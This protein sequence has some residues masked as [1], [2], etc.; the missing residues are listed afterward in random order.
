MKGLKKIIAYLLGYLKDVFPIKGAN[1]KDA[2]SSI[3][4]LFSLFTFLAMAIWF[5]YTYNF[6]RGILDKERN[7]G[8]YFIW[9]MIYYAVP[10]LIGA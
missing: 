9:N 10:Y 8:L 7:R 3:L 6:E 4:L 5:N 2:T 1:K